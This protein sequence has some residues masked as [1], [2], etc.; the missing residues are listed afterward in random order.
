MADSKHGKPVTLVIDAET[1]FRLDELLRSALVNSGAL[2]PEDNQSIRPE[3]IAVDLDENTAAFF[4][5]M[6]RDG[7][8]EAGAAH[9]ANNRSIAQA[10][11]KGSK[12]TE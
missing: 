4:S 2:S 1:A 12:K 9:Q 10:I 8:I 5:D 11:K 7:L 6:L 3:R